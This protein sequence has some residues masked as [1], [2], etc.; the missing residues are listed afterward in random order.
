MLLK[1]G[2]VGLPN[3][4]KSTL[5]NA[6]TNSQVE[7][8]NYPFATIEPNV[9]VVEIKDKRVDRLRDIFDSKKKIYNQ[10]IFTDIAGLVKGA[11]KGEGLGNKFLSNIRECDA[12]VHVVRFFDKQDIIHVEN[13]IDPKRD[14]EIID[15]EL[16]LSDID[17]LERWLE[18]NRKKLSGSN[19]KKDLQTL[20]AVNK[21]LEFLKQEKK[22]DEVNLTQEEKEHLKPFFLL[23]LKPTIYLLNVSEEDLSNPYSN[24]LIKTFKEQFD[25][26]H[27]KYVIASTQIEY[28]I[29][30]LDEESQKEFLNELGVKESG[31]NLLSSKAFELLGLATYFTCGPQEIHAWAFKIGWTAP[32]CAGVIH[33]DFER[34][35]IKA[36]VYTFNDIDQYGNENSLKEKGLLRIEGKD[37]KFKDGDVTHFRFNV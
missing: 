18:R 17:Q 12:I 21:A 37:Y 23:T 15:I 1:I 10:I 2:I 8:A 3:V 24:N 32:Q 22:L 33:T 25:N 14:I 4:G 7:A 27:K 28:E 30:K 13:T 6:I 31:I 20:E 35:F 16:I 34:G 11:S 19:D 29:S 9:G 5:F 26:E 36:E